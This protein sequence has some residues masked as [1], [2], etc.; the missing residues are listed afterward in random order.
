MGTHGGLTKVENRRAKMSMDIS[1]RPSPDNF[2]ILI[3]LCLKFEP[4]Q[5]HNLLQ[6]GFSM[7]CMSTTSQLADG[8]S[9]ADLNRYEIK[10]KQNCVN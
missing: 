10:N 1:V 4:T 2:T 6:T 7:L 5:T 9:H 8:H 3:M